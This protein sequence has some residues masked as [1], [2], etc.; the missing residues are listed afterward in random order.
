MN[1]LYLQNIYFDLS[2]V[3]DFKIHNKSKDSSLIKVED[4][5][6]IFCQIYQSNTYNLIIPLYKEMFYLEENIFLKVGKMRYN[7]WFLQ[8]GNGRHLIC[9]DQGNRSIVIYETNLNL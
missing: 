9:S 5:I 2:K 4:Y 1:V 3:K 8:N 6:P 7:G